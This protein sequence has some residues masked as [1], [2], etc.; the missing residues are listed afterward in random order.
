M[1]LGTWFH[2]MG[3]GMTA[4]FVGGDFLYLEIYEN[5]GGIAYSD[6]SNSYLSQSTAAALT[7][8]GG[9]L[10][11]TIAGAL[12]IVAAKHT[13]SSYIVLWV[14]V[15][16]LILSLLIWIKSL[17]AWI[18]LA[19]ITAMLIIMILLKKKN[20]TALTLLF[21]GTQCAFSS[22][23]QIGYLFTKQFERGGQIQY[24]DT[25][26]IASHLFGT[27]WMW[28]LL[29][30]ISSIWVLYRSYRYYLSR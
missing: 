21:L 14:L 7:A 8:A 2:E 26:V 12:L 1:L 22:Y 20:A 16:V 25:Q 6:L 30:L 11:P 29:I 18:V 23:L 19:L 28:G 13:R 3:H 27:Y 24:S 5:G 10:G 4:L 9:L 17:V 15:S